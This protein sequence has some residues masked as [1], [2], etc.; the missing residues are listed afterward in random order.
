MDLFICHVV[1]VLESGRMFA[2]PTVVTVTFDVT[3]HLQVLGSPLSV[4]FVSRQFDMKRIVKFATPFRLSLTYLDS[5]QARLCMTAH[6]PA[7]TYH[8]KTH[9]VC[10]SRHR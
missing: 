10:F 3:K 8:E 5:R 4:L 6:G 7:G 2:I 1:S 9:W